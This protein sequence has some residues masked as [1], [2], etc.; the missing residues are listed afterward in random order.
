MKR[1]TITDVR[2]TR[3]EDGEFFTARGCTW[4]AVN[5]LG[6]RFGSDS[7][8]AARQMAEDY[9][10]GRKRIDEAPRADVAMDP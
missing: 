6:Y 9:S 5:S 4:I 3:P 2:P 7:A 1:P 8:A 10:S